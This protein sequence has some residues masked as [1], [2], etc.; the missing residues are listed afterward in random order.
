MDEWPPYQG[1][2]GV[3]STMEIDTVISNGKLV[4][5]D[6]VTS[7]DLAIKGEQIVAVGEKELFP[8]AE[9][10]ID[11]G[12][13]YVLPGLVDQ[14]VHL[15]CYYSKD[16]YQSGTRAAALGGVTSCIAFAWQAWTND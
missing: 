7:N 12:G 9:R 13:K 6:K 15:D 5:D 14:H 4:G 8:P 2:N 3:T 11:V 1:E 16:S 10:E